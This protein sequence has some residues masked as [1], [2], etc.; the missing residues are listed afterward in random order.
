MEESTRAMEFPVNP[1][2][3]KWDDRSVWSTLALSPERQFDHWCNFVNRAHL[4]WSIDKVR[5]DNFPAFIR[6][7]RFEDFRI[8]NLS[9]ALVDIRGKRGS[10]EISS[11]AQELFNILYIVNGSERLIIDDREIDLQAGS[12]VMWDSTRPMK[13]ITG[14]NLHQVTLSVTH[15]RMRRIFPAI[16]D[17]VGIQLGTQTGPGRLFASHLLALDTDFGNLYPQ[18][19]KIILDS[20][21]QLFLSTLENQ[22]FHVS[23][24]SMIKKTKA[25]CSY[26]DENLGNLD[27]SATS[28]A[29]RFNISAR[30]LHRIFHRS[31]MTLSGYVLQ[32]RLDRCSQELSSRIYSNQSITDIAFKWGFKDS[33]TFS[34]IFKREIGVTPREFRKSALITSE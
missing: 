19:A 30:H 24:P 7:G 14:N 18:Q 9:S 6:E 20:T 3:N 22:E 28:L 15:S 32:K 1:I 26:I 34:K 29:S 2:E 31:D 11:D 21:T 17:F 12:L 5:C 4:T 16:D 33:S 25:I 27:L 13:F 10:K 8:V 23:P